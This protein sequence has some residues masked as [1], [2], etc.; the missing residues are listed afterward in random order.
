MEAQMY[1]RP[2]DERGWVI[3]KVGTKFREVYNM[4]CQGLDTTQI[5]SLL[6]GTKVNNVRQMVFRIRN[7]RRVP[8]PRPRWIMIIEGDSVQP[9]PTV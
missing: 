4:L 5:A 3:P 7:P 2:V 1:I 9:T 6:P 8:K